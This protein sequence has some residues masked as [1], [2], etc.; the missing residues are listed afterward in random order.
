MIKL[1]TEMANK[2]TDEYEKDMR[3][4]LNEKA[5]PVKFKEGNLV[6][7]YDPTCAENKK[8]NFSP[9]F[10]GPFKI[11]QT[12]DDHLVRLVSLDTGKELSHPYN[13]CKLN[14]VFTLWTPVTSKIETENTQGNEPQDTPMVHR[15]SQRIKMRHV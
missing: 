5:K 1:F 11:V 7:I 15:L 13:V 9:K 3:E 12:I 14:R 10:K 8:S 2:V 6:Y 4:R